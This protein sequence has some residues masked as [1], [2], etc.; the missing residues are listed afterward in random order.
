[1]GRI[2]TQGIRVQG[3]DLSMNHAA[4]VNLVDGELERVYIVTDIVSVSKKHKSKNVV[5]ID[6][7]K[8][9]DAQSRELARLSWW[10]N[11]IENFYDSVSPGWVQYFGIEG[12]AMDKPSHAH[13]IGEV[14]GVIRRELWDRKYKFRIHDPLS[15]KMFATFNGRAK[16]PEMVAA[17]KNRWDMDFTDYDP[18]RGK[19]TVKSP[20]G[21]QNTQTSEDLSDAYV[22][23]RLVW[24]EV[25]LRSGVVQ[26]RD[27]NPK[28]IQV[29]N[30]AT[31][32]WPVNILGRLWIYNEQ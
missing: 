23:A 14:S 30:R 25:R 26:L 2:R 3:W 31:R 4:I 8:H 1:M 16:K 7:N 19:P 15:V 9:L 11:W 12:Y 22:V 20:H 5:L 10:N 32:Y 18:P 28:E 27:Y 6:S 17:V 21:S 24:E 13:Q 29:F